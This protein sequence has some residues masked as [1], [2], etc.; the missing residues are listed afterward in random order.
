MGGLGSW[1]EDGKWDAGVKK[2]QGDDCSQL[3]DWRNQREERAG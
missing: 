3:G 2:K 1:T